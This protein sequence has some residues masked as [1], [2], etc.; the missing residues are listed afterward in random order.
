MQNRDIAISLRQDFSIGHDCVRDKSQSGPLKCRESSPTEILPKVHLMNTKKSWGLLC[1]TLG[2]LGACTTEKGDPTA[3][4][5]DDYLQLT[6]STAETRV[7]LNENGAGTFSEGDKVGLFISNGSST[8]YRELTYTAG[9]WL[10]LLR[11]SEF[12]KGDLA[13]TAHYPAQIDA[14]NN[15]THTVFSLT[16]DQSADGYTATDL[17]FARKNIPAG[18]YQAEMTFFHALH[19]LRIEIKGEGISTPILRS[20]MNG[21]VN[22]LTSEVTVSEDSFGWISPRKNSDGSYEA[23]IFPQTVESYRD[24]EGLIK[25]PTTA[26][27]IIYKAPDQLNG[28]PFTEFKAGKQ[29]TIRLNLASSDDQKWANR[30]VWVYGIKPPEESAWF[31]YNLQY[32]Y[33]NYYLPWKAE[34]GWFDCNKVN[35]HGGEPDGMMCWA[36]AA[37]NMLHW[38]IAQNKSYV[39]RYGDKYTGPDYTYPLQKEQSSDIFK[40]FADTFENVA[41]YGDAGVNWFIHGYNKNLSLPRWDNYNE[42]GY[43]KDVFPKD[44]YLGSNVGGLS[45]ERFNETIKDALSNQKAIGI[46]HGSV[47][48][49]HIETIWGAE[50]DEN[51]VVSA[52]Y[53]AD[54]NDPEYFIDKKIG[55]ARYK[56]VYETY[57]GTSATY[58]CYKLGYTENNKSITINRLFLLSLGQEYW[59]EYFAKQASQANLK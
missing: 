13:L 53:M 54:N 48:A 5:P 45:K 43:F 46:S 27:E 4:W 39:D 31:Q 2:I 28:E 33:E 12:G 1:L 25:I 26:H 56:I 36:A 14:T 42:A 47:T 11:R 32:G 23:V 35:P 8:E 7:D 21:T 9:E 17:L 24:K 10:P 16:K 19:R 37:S 18:S 49:G 6:F 58:T 20:R 51:G 59:E 34:Y 52:I 30:K 29:L 57:T 40:C 38:W 50:F 41:G 44:V 55:C 15:P 22:L 3:E